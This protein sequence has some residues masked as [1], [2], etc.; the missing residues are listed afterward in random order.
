MSQSRPRPRRPAARTHITHIFSGVDMM[1]LVRA[2]LLLLAWQ[3]EEQETRDDP[4]PSARPDCETTA[5]SGNALE[6]A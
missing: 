2:R 1:P 5:Q 4:G 3:Q 6:E